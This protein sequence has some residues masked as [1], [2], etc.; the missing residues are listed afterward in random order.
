MGSV[1]PFNSRYD[2]Q[3]PIPGEV[4]VVMFWTECEFD[5]CF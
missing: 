2:R 4:F 1:D 3:P 5:C